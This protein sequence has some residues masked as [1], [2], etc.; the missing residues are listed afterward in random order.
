MKRIAWIDRLSKSIEEDLGTKCM[1][2]IMTGGEE[3]TSSTG[4]RKK[5]EWVAQAMQKLSE[6]CSLE[7]G[8]HIMSRS[9]CS[10]PK[11]KLHALKNIYEKDGIHA[12]V[13]TIQEDRKKRVL[14]ALGY[15]KNLLQ[16]AENEPW[17]LSPT[18]D[19]DNTIVIA[20]IPYHIRA[21]MNAETRSERQ[22]HYCHCGWVNASLE[23]IPLPF[24]YCGAGYHQQLLEGISDRPV[25]VNIVQTVMHGADFCRFSCKIPV[26]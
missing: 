16:K 13:R 18:L 14:W 25:K 11:K 21:Y 12:F 5:A 1:K 22:L 2:A 15:D 20:T 10:Y 6:S 19:K 7:T 23:P 9:S 3:L 4:P 26:V 8:K 24:C 17:Y